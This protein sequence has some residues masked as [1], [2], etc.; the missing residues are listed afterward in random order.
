MPGRASMTMS[1]AIPVQPDFRTLFEPV[2]GAYLVLTLIE[3]E[4][5]ESEE[6]CR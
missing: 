2:P 1:S 5:L 6:V 3:H 4:H